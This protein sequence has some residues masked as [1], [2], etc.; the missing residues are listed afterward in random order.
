MSGDRRGSWLLNP[1]DWD[2]GWHV[3]VTDGGPRPEPGES[4]TVTR[5]DGSDS[6]ETV[7]AAVAEH[8]RL[9]DGG[10]VWWLCAVEATRPRPPLPDLTEHGPGAVAARPKRNPWVAALALALWALAAVL[11]CA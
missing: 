4:V 7:V 3:L 2:G 10:P 1:F 6:V 9:A 8:R 11:W 5:R